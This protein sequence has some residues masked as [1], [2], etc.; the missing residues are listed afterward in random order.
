[1]SMRMRTELELAGDGC[2]IQT[3]SLGSN[4]S[5]PLDVCVALREISDQ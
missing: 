2:E 4:V 3:G 5:R 1:M